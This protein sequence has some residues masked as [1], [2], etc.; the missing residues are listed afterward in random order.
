MSV[1]RKALTGEP[2]P[3]FWLDYE[4]PHLYPKQEAAIFDE[5]RY[6]LIE[7]STKAGKAQPLNA[8]V[9]TP[10]GPIRMGNIRI[11]QTVLTPDGTG[12]VTAIYPQGERE[13]WRVT[14]SDGAIVE[15]DA[16]HLWEVHTFR[17]N[18]EIMTTQEILSLPEWRF[19]RSWIPEIE[20]CA[21]ASQKVPVDPYLLGV[22]I[23]D[24][25]LT[26]ESVILSSADEEILRE[27]ADRIPYGHELV[28]RSRHDWCIS[29]GRDGA[30]LRERKIHLRGHLQGL[31]L[32]G[33]GSHEKFVPD[34]YRYNSPFVRRA[35]LQGILDTDGFVDKRGQPTI[36][37]TSERLA[38]D[39]T[40][41]VQSLGG[42]VLTRLRQEN[43]Y[44]DKDGRFV[45]CRPVWRQR[46]R[47]PN[48]ADLFRLRRKRDACRRK[49][50]IGHRMFRKI[51][52]ARI[53]E[54]QCIQ[55]DTERQLYLTDG[56]I[57]T[58]NTSGCIT[59]LVEQ[60]LAGGD[61]RN[62]WW[63][64]PVSHQAMIAFD[65]MR[66]ALP[67]DVCKAN[68]S[69]KTLTLMNGAVIWFKSGDKPNCYDQDT[70]ILTRRGWR[71]F[72]DIDASDEVLTRSG[73]GAAEWQ[74]PTRIISAPYAGEMVTIENKRLDLCVTPNHRM[75]IER[76]RGGTGRGNWDRKGPRLGTRSVKTEM[77]VEANALRAKDTLPSWC[78]WEGVDAAEITEDRCALLGFYLAEGSAIGNASL[79]PHDMVKKYGYR[80]FFAQTRGLKGGDKGDVRA[81]FAEVLDRLGYKYRERRDGLMLWDKQ[82][83]SE[84]IGL[85]NKYTKYVPA[86][87]KELPPEKLRVLLRW[88]VLGDGSSRRG[89]QWTY[90][91]VSRRLAD[92]VQEIALKCGWNATIEERAPQPFG[93]NG[94]SGGTATVGYLVKIQKH[95]LSHHLKSSDRSYVGRLPY[96][97]MVHCVSVPNGVVM[98]R[99]NGK[100]AWSG[101]SLYGEDVY[102]AVIDE[103]SRFKEDA[104]IAI[105]STL[106][107]TRAPIRIIG[108]VRGRKNWFYKMA[109]VAER[110]QLLGV[111]SEMGYHKIVAADAVAAGV[112][113]QREIDD[114]RGQ[115]PE[116]WFR[117]L[118]Y[119]EP[120]DDGGNPFGL[121]HIEAIVRPETAVNSGV[122]SDKPPRAWGWDLAK[123]RDFCVGIGLD[124]EGAIC[125]FRRFNGV[126]WGE[127]KNRIIAEVGSAPALVDSTGVGDPIVEDI[128]R[129]MGEHVEHGKP[130]EGCKL[131][132]YIFTP[133]SKQ[134]LME[135]LAVAIQD[136]TVWIADNVVRQ[137]LEQFEFELTRTGVKYCMVPDTPVLTA[138]LRYLQVGSLR[139]GN[140][141]L[142]FDENP[143]DPRRMRRWR[144]AH[145][146][147]VGKVRRPCYRLHLSDGTEFVCSQEHRWLVAN[148][149][150]PMKWL[151]TDKLRGGESGGPQSAH[152]LI[153]V[154][155]YWKEETS[156][157]AGYLAS[158]FDG[159]GSLSQLE[160]YGR[161]GSVF[162]LSL[163]QRENPMLNQIR[164]A[165]AHFDFTWAEQRGNGTNGDVTHVGLTGRISEC[166]RLLGQIRPKRLLDNFDP[167]RIGAMMANET[168]AIASIEFVGEREVIAL[169]TTSKTFIAAGFATHNSAPEGYFDDCVCALALAR[170]CLVIVPAPVKVTQDLLNRARL[171]VPRRRH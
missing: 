74:R 90:F 170:M 53:A 54:T 44:R 21:F 97:G 147:E 139:P 15:A 111:A 25:G 24:G 98:V 13:V 42:S 55:L 89:D 116:Q 107:Y 35:V 96:D 157:Q 84:L 47:V 154:A 146:T 114:A 31:G 134:K 149:A 45:L 148:N 62:Y 169:G 77:I 129:M 142:A 112:L 160:R 60:A 26:G 125:R 100:P 23:G 36:E 91:T 40:E 79:R 72:K 143:Q 75:L 130:V 37:Q 41:I 103:A 8:L 95:G 81:Q 80:V 92:D 137:E 165:L 104:Y 171:M 167:N 39:I 108:N 33:K 140:A 61:G 113:E 101:N 52:F 145:V 48:G 118:Y 85:G 88:M 20:P 168:V 135:G 83:W 115:M 131:Q 10:S 119:A 136:R 51:E 159:E 126:P 4:R 73:S 29:A 151:T 132:G 120:S 78:R 57:P 162:R 56:L 68:I 27:V 14:F 43:G 150:G 152:R 166:L 12:C 70:E 102:G 121:Q 16:D 6:S 22:L 32:G 17:R 128:Q 1:A 69:L 34:I 11:G 153:R 46:I 106:T 94:S 67:Q 124:D 155:P 164:R 66:R 50:K 141:L 110:N 3:D 144:Q 138:D 38:R 65:R 93:R 7:A 49:R 117:E 76:R 122:V 9:Y 156:Y 18:P 30:L 64:A 163:A 99:R 59:W 158:A 63:V 127:V 161:H 19:I 82:M 28:H 123:K 87:V 109:R 58:H 2:L 133:G 105:R 5:H 71:L 86:R